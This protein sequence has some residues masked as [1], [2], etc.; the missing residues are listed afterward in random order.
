MGGVSTVVI[1][2]L[3]PSK[4]ER[5]LKDGM[6]GGLGGRGS[7]ELLSTGGVQAEA[8]S[9]LTDRRQSCVM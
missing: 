8:G 2:Y 1:F 7:N 3:T 4:E 9:S 6:G 5:F